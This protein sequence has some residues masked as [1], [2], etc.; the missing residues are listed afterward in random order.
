MATTVTKKWGFENLLAYPSLNKDSDFDGVADGWTKITSPN[1]DV[2]FVFDSVNGAQAIVV[3]SATGQGFP[4]V[5]SEMIPVSPGSDYTLSAEMKGEGSLIPGSSGTGPM[6]QIKWF[7]SSQSEI[8]DTVQ[9]VQSVT[10]DQY[11][12]TFVTGTAPNNAAYARVCLIFRCEDENARG[13]VWFR[14]AMFQQGSQM[15]DYEESDFFTLLNVA[16]TYQS[17]WYIVSDG[18]NR[19][20]QAEQLP[21]GSSTWSGTQIKYFV[22]KESEN[23]KMKVQYNVS[24]ISTS[25]RV[26]IFV[27][28]T[29]RYA[30]DG[31]IQNPIN[32]TLLDIPRGDVIVT[33]RQERSSGTS[34]GGVAWLD[35]ISVTWDVPESVPE[36][37]L[38]EEKKVVKY[39]DFESESHDPFFTVMDKA[40]GYTYGF[41]RT[42]RHRHS[43]YFAYTVEDTADSGGTDEIGRPPTIPHG[44]KAGALIR[45]KVPL[46]AIDP[47]IELKAMFFAQPQSEKGRVYLNGGLIWEGTGDI[48]VWQTITASLIPG[49]VNEL[50]LEF[51][52]DASGYLYDDTVY[53]DDIIVS[54]NLPDAPLFYIGT[55]A[56]TNILTSSKNVTKTLGFEGWSDYQGTYSD[57]FFTIV[58]KGKLKSGG[59]KSQY[60]EA[61]WKKVAVVGSVDGNWNGK[62]TTSGYMLKADR[63]ST[64]NNEDAA[65]DLII[66]VPSGVTNAKLEFWNIAELERQASATSGN[67]YPRMYEE[68][69][70]WIN[71]SIWKMFDWCSP[72]SSL[73]NS[74]AYKNAWVCPWG[75]WWKET[76]PLTPGQ[77]YTISFELQRDAGDSSPIHGRDLLAVDD[78][79]VTWTETNGRLQV[80]P[81]KIL[82]KLDGSDG[83]KALPGRKGAEMPP[84]QHAEYEVYGQ[85]G[86]V[87]Q[88][89]RIQA[90]QLDQPMRIAGAT[91]EEVRQKI[92]D[93]TSQIANRDISLGMAYP[94]GDHRVLNCR[95]VSGLEGEERSSLETFKRYVLSVKAFD[96]FWY[97]EPETLGVGEVKQSHLIRNTGDYELYPII[98]VY[99]ACASGFQV[100]LRDE[101]GQVVSS[102]TINQALTAGQ[103]IICDTR[104]GRKTV[105]R[106]SNTS[107]YQ[108]LSGDLFAVPQGDWEIYLSATGTDS[109]TKLEI[110]YQIPYFTV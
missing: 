56:Q 4:G 1:T 75:R 89:S 21:A 58:N 78:I 34:S 107:W 14:N 23:I 82:F 64:K 70:I 28:G 108:Y 18:T 97:S 98:R 24:Q 33:I 73:T 36:I 101:T 9:P 96:P 74:V 79:K 31:G 106:D 47:T 110:D 88:F 10:L 102:F 77:T 35:D 22:P 51:E 83:Y 26:A 43:G 32:L 11:T 39:L 20:L 19:F 53:F 29:Q 71:G 66:S 100:Q 81:P 25:E 105:I 93:L 67:K 85:P 6:L 54:Y 44:A 92:R 90:R 48:L 91:P 60:P 76:I 17:G 5:H 80:I 61:G 104:P 69:R 45:F 15:T 94:N 13:E 37:V 62:P 50:L 86:S 38:P 40:P 27:N 84:I 52:K 87:Y 12:R 46:V 41:E 103:F 63:P 16:P 55:R 2:E 3:Y 30:I 57:D 65:F 99:G 8:E 42:F 72:T 68:Y 49:A 95:Y 59:G 109:N 7:D